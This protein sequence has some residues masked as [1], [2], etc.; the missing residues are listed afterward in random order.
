MLQAIKKEKRQ[1]AEVGVYC[2]VGML[3]L[4]SY[5]PYTNK[6][7]SLLNKN[8]ARQ[9]SAVAIPFLLSTLYNDQIS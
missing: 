9:Q 1:A 3:Q 2:E 6:E 5:L 4:K 7:I 8:H